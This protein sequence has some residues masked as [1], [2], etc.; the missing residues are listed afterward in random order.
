M[1]ESDIY[2]F[3]GE[4]RAE[5]RAIRSLLET[6]Q[7]EN[8]DTVK[9]VAALEVWKAGVMSQIKTWGVVITAIWALVLFF[10]K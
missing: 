5:L 10:F 7:A 6:H 9:R 1:N 4:V 2:T 8:A 3:I